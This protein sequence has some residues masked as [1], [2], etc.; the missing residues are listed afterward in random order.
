VSAPLKDVRGRL[1][2]FRAF[3][4]FL[5]L[6]LSARLF[7]IQ[8]LNADESIRRAQNQH[9]ER[10]RVAPHRGRILDRHDVELAFTA[11]NPTIVVD[12][13]KLDPAKRPALANRL[14]PILGIPAAEIARKLDSTRRDLR[15]NPGATAVVMDSLR[16]FPREVAVQL[17]PKRIYPYGRAAA[18]V[19]GFVGV[20]QEGI[21]GLEVAWDRELRGRPGWATYLRDGHQNRMSQGI[22][23]A[24][25][26][27]LD[28]VLTIDA[29]FQEVVAER[30][31]AAV[32][33]CKA[34]S[35]YVI[36]IEPAT[37]DI[38]AMANS[39]S[40]DPIEYRMAKPEQLRNRLISDM[41]E[42]GSTIKGMTV[43]AA[44]EDGSYRP[45]TP[46][47]CHMGS[48]RLGSRTITD[49]DPFGI[50]PLIDTFAH[51]SNIAMAQIGL[52]LG[53]ERMYHH[54][55]KFGFAERT[56]LGLPGEAPGSLRK[57]ERWTRDTAASVAFGYEILVTPLQMAM[58]YSALAND[59]VLM[60]P[61]LVRE[62]RS[63]DVVVSTT[64]VQEVRRAVSST[65]ATT[66]LEFMEHTVVEG[67]GKK[68]AVDWCRVGGKT[69]TARK[70]DP[71]LKQYITRHYAS[72]VG[73][74]PAD[75]PRLLIYAVIDEPRGD[76]YGGSTAAP[77]FREIIEASWRLEHPLIRPD[78]DVVP[79]LAAD[80]TLRTTPAGRGRI[81][82]AGML[83]PEAA[84][85]ETSRVA[86]LARAAD[87]STDTL[88][89]PPRILGRVPDLVGHSVRQ[90]LREAGRA[91][92]SAEIVG[93]GVVIDQFP[94]PGDPI[95]EA[96]GA[97]IILYLG[98]RAEL[99]ERERDEDS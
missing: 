46:I 6:L 68:A 25:E 1:G 95:T 88:A 52:R 57:P 47:D 63:G 60:K 9:I 92:L 3:G 2:L 8:V 33:A 37:G 58:A 94:G 86:A 13:A 32:A 48:W 38:L 14:A 98:D 66:L 12:A 53:R 26:P 29:E 59:G 17:Q 93:D 11:E 76:I 49:H 74:A 62:V 54:L 7:W 28:L 80:P 43:S 87:D 40:Y 96:T 56:G 20:D 19:T 5:F 82:M 72:F 31:D 84:V 83:A 22:E 23:R 10:V 70:F 64:P 30:L 67:T 42:P 41:I 16:D 4:V 35:G 51:S 71:E 15:L 27:G 34:K 78:V 61:R 90:A 99:A 89:P 24:A 69:G 39:P 73:V 81:A 91:G 55:R 79:A 50:L 85:A 21:E 75:D 45:N 44:L 77:L 65:T 18:H 36:V 97:R